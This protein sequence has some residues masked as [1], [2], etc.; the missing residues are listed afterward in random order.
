MG[1]YMKK[2]FTLLLSAI[3]VFVSL[4]VTYADAGAKL[5]IPVVTK[6]EAVSAAENYLMLT[7]PELTDEMDLKDGF[8]I[9]YNKSYPFGY[10][11]S[12]RRIINGIPYGTDCISMFVDSETA[13]VSNFQ[14]NFSDDIIIGDKT[15][16]I[17]KSAAREQFIAASGLELRYNKKI[18]G[19]NISTYLTY[20]ADEDFVINAETSNTISVPYELPIDKYFNVTYMSEKTSDTAYFDST[21]LSASSADNIVRSIPEFGVMDYYTTV[22]ANY[23]RS[24][25]G[26]YLITILYEYGNNTKTVTVNA[27]NGIP[28]EYENNSVS[29]VSSEKSS[30]TDN[31]DNFTEKYY[32]DYLKQTIRYQYINDDYTV[33]LYERQVEGIPYKSNGL[34]VCYDNYGNL[35][36]VSFAWDN[37]EFARP[38]EIL[39][40]EEAYS[41]FFQRCDLELSYFKRDNGQIVPIY[42]TSSSGTGIIDAV[43]GRQLNY[44]GSLYYSEKALNYIDINT[45]YASEAAIRLSDC[46]IYVS[47]GNVSLDEY[48]SQQEYLLLISELITGTKPILNTTGILTDDQREMLYTYMYSENV[49]TKSETDYTSYVTRAGAVKYLIRILGYGTVAD[50]TEIFIPHFTDSSSIPASLQGYVE[51]AR[52]LG[53]INGYDDNSFR[54][55]DY[56]TNGDSLIMVYNYLKR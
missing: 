19:K 1:D 22:S 9:K 5:S 38:D 8:T 14:V 18:S 40:L 27:I 2:I 21:V 12:Y 25:D 31:I 30:Q 32:S 26:T 45:H 56:I 47:S 17:D 39:S 23:L 55:N 46:D 43:S 10:N 53:I 50:M 15:Q 33:C 49:I 28:I 35:K 54:A 6:A 51:L 48:I 36:Y 24:Q 29:Y 42:K 13:E 7:V 41:A 11:I 3:L 37:I 16:L 44:D 34:Y 4:C 20:T 52:S